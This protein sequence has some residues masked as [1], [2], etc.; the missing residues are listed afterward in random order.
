MVIDFSLGYNGPNGLNAPRF[1]L[2]TVKVFNVPSFLAR[3]EL[4]EITQNPLVLGHDGYWHLQSNLIEA[5]SREIQE[6][7]SEYNITNPSAETMGRITRHMEKDGNLILLPG[8]VPAFALR[9]RKWG[10]LTGPF[11][12]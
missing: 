9:N 3:A 2:P 10:E 12:L 8:T 11:T 5:T 7:M 6:T 4:F 1:Q